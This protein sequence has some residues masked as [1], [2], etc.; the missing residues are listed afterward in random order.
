MVLLQPD[1]SSNRPG[2]GGKYCSNGIDLRAKKKFTPDEAKQ[3]EKERVKDRNAKKAGTTT[4]LKLPI[5]SNFSHHKIRTGMSSSGA[6]KRLKGTDEHTEVAQISNLSALASELHK[7]V[8]EPCSASPR[9][10]KHL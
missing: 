1:S 10:G 5:E 6:A 8:R 3:R 7:K 2:A 4:D 9:C